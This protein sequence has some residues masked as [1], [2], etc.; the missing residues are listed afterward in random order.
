MHLAWPCRSSVRGTASVGRPAI[1]EVATLLLAARVAHPSWGPAKLVQYLTPRHAC[2]RAWPAISTV[3]DLLKRH[4]LVR[5]RRRRRPIVHPG[6]VPIHTT[7]PNDSWTADFKGQF[8]TRNG[9]YCYPLTIADQ[10]TRCRT[11]LTRRRHARPSG[12]GSARA[13]RAVH[14]PARARTSCR[15]RDRRDARS[16]LQRTFSAV[17][18]VERCAPKQALDMRRR[19]PPRRFERG[20]CIRDWSRPT[21]PGSNQSPLSNVS[22]AKRSNDQGVDGDD[23]TA[24]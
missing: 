5:P 3:A 17:R 19:S 15:G 24:S 20:A 4:A 13:R 10:H 1:D 8:R 11:R 9:I 18:G 12:G 7:A 22:A 16:T 14:R 6:T 21:R 23:F 2:V